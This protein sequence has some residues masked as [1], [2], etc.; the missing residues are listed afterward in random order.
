MD[1]TVN[2]C[3]IKKI[4]KNKYETRIRIL[5]NSIYL[6]KIIN[7]HMIAVIY[8]LNKEGLFL[9][10]KMV[11]ITEGHVTVFVLCKHFFKDFG[12]PQCYFYVDVIFEKEILAKIHIRSQTNY[13][14]S[15]L[16]L[17]NPELKKCILVPLEDMNMVCHI[18]SDH[19]VYIETIINIKSHIELPEQ[20]EK[21][22]LIVSRKIMLRTKQFIEKMKI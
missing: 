12:A 17:L 13:N 8:E 5:N 15:K 18:N 6:R 20:F 1:D 10:F 9:D 3:E 11:E 22:A 14:T 7:E 2:M 21:I 4:E 19:D 16:L